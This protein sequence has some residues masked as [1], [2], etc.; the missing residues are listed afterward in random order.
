MAADIKDPDTPFD[1]NC[2]SIIASFY[3]QPVS[4]LDILRHIE[5]LNP[6]KSTGPDRILIKFIIMSAEIIAPTLTELY[7]L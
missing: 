1:F 4:V 5:Q 6:N 2:T 3:F 7:N